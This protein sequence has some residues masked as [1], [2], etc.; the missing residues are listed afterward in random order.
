MEV[1]GTHT[2]AISGFGIRRAVDPRLKLLSGPGCPVCVTP[3]EDIDAAIEL[4]SRP[5]VVLVSFGDMMRVPGTRSSLEKERA[6]GADVRI[7]YSPLDAL[8]MAVRESGREFVFLGVG[9][10]TTAPLV[11]ATV[12]EARH[13]QVANFSVLAM[14]RL[15]P[16]AL[17]AIARAKPVSVDGFILPGHVSTVIG[18]RPYE[19][20]R[21]RYGVPSC[22]TGFEALDVVQGVL[23]ILELVGREP[24]VLV[25]YRRSVRPEGNPRAEGLIEKVFDRTDS[26]WR[27]IGMIP[28]SG[29]RLKARFER[30]DAVRRYGVKPGVPVRT[31]C[32]CGEVMTGVIVPPECRLFGRACTPEEPVGPCMVSSEGACAAYY[33]YDRN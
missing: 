29:L 22:I 5:G 7:V 32:Q 4:A 31:R 8:R 14:F 26:Q 15:I 33:R 24:E 11:A 1:C 16:P 2:M 21:D 18:R 25:Q 27:G 12:L 20:L 17:D 30:F 13:A 6:R 19:F 3:Q 9:F 10:E 28:D 23:M